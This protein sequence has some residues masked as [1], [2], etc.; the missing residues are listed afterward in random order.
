MYY[1]LYGSSIFTVSPRCI[2][3]YIIE[4]RTIYK[5]LQ[6]TFFIYTVYSIKVSCV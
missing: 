6:Y 1:K 5:I 2:Y 3:D 4:I